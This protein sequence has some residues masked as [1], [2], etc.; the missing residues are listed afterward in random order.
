MRL[1]LKSVF[2]GTPCLYETFYNHLNS[3]CY[4]FANNNRLY[5]LIDLFGGSILVVDGFQEL[6]NTLRGKLSLSK[7]RD[8]MF[9]SI[10]NTN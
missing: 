2:F 8:M 5:V 9:A 10:A 3:S 4:F 1:S 6:M 7:M